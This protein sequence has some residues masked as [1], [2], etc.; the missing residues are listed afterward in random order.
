MFDVF[1]A[2]VCEGRD[3]INGILIII[4][5][6]G[7]FVSIGHVKIGCSIFDV[8]QFTNAFVCCDNFGLAG[9]LCSLLLTN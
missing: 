9:T 3:P 8:E 5:D 6:D 4:I 1:S 2:F 7:A